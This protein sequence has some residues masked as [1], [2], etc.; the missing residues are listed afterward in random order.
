MI[1]CYK[2]YMDLYLSFR[3]FKLDEPVYGSLVR[4][5]KKSPVLHSGFIG[6]DSSPIFVIVRDWMG[7]RIRCPREEIFCCQTNPLE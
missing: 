3:E 5:T 4:L 1:S 6:Y 2:N 7:T